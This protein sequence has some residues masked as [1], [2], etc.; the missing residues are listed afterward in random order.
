MSALAKPVAPSCIPMDA[1]FILG[2]NAELLIQQYFVGF[3][4]IFDLFDFPQ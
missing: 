1:C 3:Q 2:L 4:A